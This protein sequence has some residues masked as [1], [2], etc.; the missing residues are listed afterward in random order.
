MFMVGGECKGSGEVLEGKEKGS[1]AH[2]PQ[3]LTTYVLFSVVCHLT[4]EPF[5]ASESS[6]T[7]LSKPRDL[8]VWLAPFIHPPSL[9][10]PLF[11][12]RLCSPRACW[13]PT[14]LVTVSICVKVKQRVE[15]G[16]CHSARR[17]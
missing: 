11:S 6:H 2:S 3:M 17:G 16:S 4:L 10:S 15:E 9:F 1:R 12:T 5:L 13:E 8:C 7:V 14:S